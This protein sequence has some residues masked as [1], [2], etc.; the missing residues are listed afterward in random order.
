MP[1]G[2][3]REAGEAPAQAVRR[4]C[5][6]PPLEELKARMERALRDPVLLQMPLPMAGGWTR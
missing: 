1:D 3:H 2:L 6:D 5:G 4:G